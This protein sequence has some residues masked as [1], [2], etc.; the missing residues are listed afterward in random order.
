[1]GRRTLI[2]STIL[3]LVVFGVLLVVGSARSSSPSDSVQEAGRAPTTTTTT[4]PPPEG[5]VVVRLSNGVFRPANLAIDIEEVQ[6]VQ[7]IN[8]DPREYVI[9][10]S[11]GIF[12][13]P[14][15]NQGDTFEFDFSTLDPAIHRYN[16]LIGFQRIPGSVDT[17]PEQ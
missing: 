14:P 1:M 7:W 13:S 12:E 9:V 10:G 5:V 3:V 11:G 6:I 15:L 16:A 8:E 2:Q 4:E 17:R